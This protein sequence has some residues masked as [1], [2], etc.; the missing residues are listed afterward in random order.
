MDN[1]IIKIFK[2]N[3]S[4][5]AIIVVLFKGRRI[6]KYC[7]PMA[8]NPEIEINIPLKDNFSGIYFSALKKNPSIKDGAILI[9]VNRN[10]LTLK[11]FSYRVYPPPLNVSRS[12]NMGSGYNSSFD[13]SGVKRVVCIYFIN[14]NGVKKFAKGKEELLFKPKAK[15]FDKYAK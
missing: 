11:G 3:K 9:Q 14:K 10:F 12:K 13:F 15:K 1:E 6:P 7:V 4:Q 2:K 8:R 5:H